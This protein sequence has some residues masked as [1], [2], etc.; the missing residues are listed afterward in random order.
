MKKYYKLQSLSY[1]IRWKIHQSSCIL[2]RRTQNI[3]NNKKQSISIL[4]FSIIPEKKKNSNNKYFD[5]R[6]KEK[7]NWSKIEAKREVIEMNGWILIFHFISFEWITRLCFSVYRESDMN[8]TNLFYKESNM[9]SLRKRITG[10]QY[11]WMFFSVSI[12]VDIH[13]F[14][15]LQWKLLFSCK[16]QGN[17]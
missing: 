15:N 12:W 17:H 10:D 5:N 4:H 14:L 1:K 16:K 9:N 7:N 13:H 6:I 2:T 3:N 11:G 8:S